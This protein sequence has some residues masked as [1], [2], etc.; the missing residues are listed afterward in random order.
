MLHFYKRKK[1]K[2]SAKNMFD[3]DGSY[4]G[5]YSS[6]L[7]ENEMPVQDADDL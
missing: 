3:P 2:D 1:Y 7:S 4:T 5:N 6:P